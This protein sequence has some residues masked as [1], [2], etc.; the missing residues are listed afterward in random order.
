[1]DA[2]LDEMDD[3][4]KRKYSTASEVLLL[5]KPRD[6]TPRRARPAGVKPAG[7]LKVNPRKKKKGEA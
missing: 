6:A 4:G 5:A 7:S 3:K 1:M 2:K